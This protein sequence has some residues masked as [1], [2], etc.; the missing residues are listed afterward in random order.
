MR[1][2]LLS[3]SPYHNVK[4]IEYPS[5]MITTSDKDDRVHPMHSFKFMA[6]LKENKSQKN[7]IIMHVERK[8][9]HSGAGKMSAMISKSTDILA[10][11]YKE[12]GMGQR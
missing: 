7:P 11:V 2:Y 9:G 5:A 1:K 4:K 10:F 6:K 3:Y 8:A 12:L